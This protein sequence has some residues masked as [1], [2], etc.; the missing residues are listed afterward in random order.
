[1]NNASDTLFDKVED[2]VLQV[3][4]EP[5]SEFRDLQRDKDRLHEGL[6]ALGI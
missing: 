4:Q 5:Y 6:K 3:L 2:Y 1:M